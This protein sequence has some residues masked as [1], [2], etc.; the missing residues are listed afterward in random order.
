MR[1]RV[2]SFPLQILT[3]L[4][5]PLFVLTLLVAFGGVALHQAAMREMVAEHSLHT[6]SGG[7]ASLSAHLE[8]RREVLAG[9]AGRVEAGEAPA[10]VIETSRGWSW[11]LFDGGLAFYD[12]TGRLMAAAPSQAGWPPTVDGSAVQVVVEPGSNTTQ[13]IVLAA[14]PTSGEGATLRAAGM[15]SL[16]AL[17]LAE[18]AESVHPDDATNLYLVGPDRQLLYHSDPERVGDSVRGEIH[19]SDA[20]RGESGT[21]LL[22][23]GRQEIIATFAPVAA[24]RWALVQE[25]QWQEALGLLT[26]YSQAA[27]LI[28]V[29][30]LLIAVGAMWFGVR[31]IVQPLRRLEN[32]A[33]ELAWG[34]FSSIEQPVGGIDEIRQLQAT[35]RHLASRVRSAQAGM[36]SYIGAITQ[37]Q[38]EERARLARELHDQTAQSLVAIGQREQMLKRYLVDDPKA[39][40]LLAELRAMTTLAV[41]DLRRIIRAMRPI[42]LEELGLVPA[43]EMLVHD[44]AD[45]D[46]RM[47]ASFEKQGAPQRLPPEH[48]IA[49]YRVVQEALN[50]AWLHSDASRVSLTVDFG[51]EAVTATVRDDGRGFTAPRRITDLSEQGHFGIMGMVERAA[52]IG[53]H[54]QIESAPGEGTAVIIRVPA[55]SSQPDAPTPGH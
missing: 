8:Q 41:D 24:A 30:G 27:P 21:A 26:R 25:E 4:V 23:V 36:R 42:Y 47:K 7:A 29:P 48:E 32:R 38:E 13:V 51:D 20:L 50:N 33:T 19:V 22:R 14:P 34:D 37:A 39:A 15:V 44:L 45:R 31:R 18:I 1:R 46:A 17:G 16:Q 35:L 2:S 53:A 55:A 5:L 49:L 54:L 12:A 10:D 3:F 40:G 9:L 43:L 11:A 28:L 6:I 52:L